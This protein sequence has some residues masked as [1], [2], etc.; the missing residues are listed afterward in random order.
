MKSPLRKQALA[1]WKAALRAADPVEAVLRHVA[2]RNGVLIVGKQRYKLSEFQNIYVVGAGKASAAMAVAVERLLRKQITEGFVNVK[3]GHLAKLR[4]IHLNECGHPVPDEAGVRG[5]EEIGRI[6]AKAGANDLVLFLVSGGASALLPSP[7]LGIT[8]AEKQAVT[9]LLLRSGANINEM[10]AVRKHIS[11][12]KGGRLAELA[13]PA[14]VISLIL[15]DVIGDKLDVIGSGPTAPDPSTFAEA[16]TILEKYKLT[17]Q[18][19]ASIRTQ[20]EDGVNGKIPE[21]PKRV[22][23]TQ[24][25]VV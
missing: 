18:I 4:R 7:A 22:D 20:I 2:V 11:S 12:L 24:N 5:A 1:I 17:G 9:G 15:S 21:T 3:Y 19:A 10:N 6:A 13:K 25:I 23:R 14:T 8:L 16:K